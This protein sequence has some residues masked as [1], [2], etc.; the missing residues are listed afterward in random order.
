MLVACRLAGLP[1]LRRTML[2]T[3]RERNLAWKSN[4]SDADRLTAMR[5]PDSPP[6]SAASPRN[7]AAL[8]CRLA[9]KFK[10]SAFPIDAVRTEGALST[11]LLSNAG[12]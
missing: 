1:R 11:E 10:E 4:R 6:R 9:A 3:T 5:R 2:M 12:F 8:Q 7:D